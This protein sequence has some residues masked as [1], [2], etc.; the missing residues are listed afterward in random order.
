MNCKQLELFSIR[1][2]SI[3]DEFIKRANE[4]HNNFYDYS[5]TV[6]KKTTE[7]VIIICPK[8]GIFWQVPKNHLGKKG[9]KKC[10]IEKVIKKQALTKEEFIENSKLI[11]GE[12]YIYDLVEYTNNITKVKIICTIHGV[13]KQAPSNHLR[14]NGCHKCAGTIKINLKTFIKKSN[15]VH[16]NFYDYSKIQN[17]DE[18]YSKVEIIC[19]KHGIFWQVPKNHLRG[20]GCSKCVHQISK[21]ETEWLD[22]IKIPN[23][24]QHRQVVIKVENKH[25]RVDGFDPNT[26]TVYEFLGD[27]WHGNPT[28]FDPKS[29]H[30]KRKI[31]YEDLYI[32]TIEKFNLLKK[33]NYNLVYIWESEY[34]NQIQEQNENL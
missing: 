34:K 25:F 19:P 3:N 20:C 28:V 8:H 21:D 23:D 16:Q 18:T 32:K 29:I 14:G 30:P 27:Y 11:H 9:C 13:F 6:Y 33:A 1:K 12:I 15:K 22:S 2:R 7:K 24:K 4:I 31:T 5:M 10:G 17:F 26:N